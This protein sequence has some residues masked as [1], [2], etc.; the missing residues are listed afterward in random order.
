M[1]ATWRARKSRIIDTCLH[2]LVD[3]EGAVAGLEDVDLVRMAARL[4][5]LDVA[6]RL[7]V[8]DSG[9]RSSR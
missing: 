6:H 9:C 2:A 4:Q 5:L 7:P 3:V 8:R 1:P